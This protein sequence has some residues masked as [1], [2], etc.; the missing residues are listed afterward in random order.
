MPTNELEVVSQ[1]V[2]VGSGASVTVYGFYMVPPDLESLA[3]VLRR[4]A[5]SEVPQILRVRIDCEVTRLAP[6]GCVT[7][8]ELRIIDCGGGEVTALTIEIPPE[9]N[10]FTDSVDVTEHFTKCGAGVPLGIN[11]VKVVM[12]PAYV[13]GPMGIQYVS[14]SY[15]VRVKVFFS[16]GW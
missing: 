13:V 3:E 5:G 2:D 12:E 10:A 6:G 4:K 15:Y 14:A 11:A 9:S 16:W 7:H 1:R 8:G